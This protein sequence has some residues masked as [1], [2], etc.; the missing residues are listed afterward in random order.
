MATI[1]F[2][3]NKPHAN[4]TGY[5]L[6]HVWVEQRNGLLEQDLHLLPPNSLGAR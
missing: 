6:I 4:L 2:M 3:A 5:I 1:N